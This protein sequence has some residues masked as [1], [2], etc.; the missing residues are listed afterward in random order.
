ML[1]CTVWNLDA[2]RD[3]GKAWNKK[4]DLTEGRKEGTLGWLPLLSP[5]V[6]MA[7]ETSAAG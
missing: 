1:H 6:V 5:A 3:A 4:Q 7:G 2:S